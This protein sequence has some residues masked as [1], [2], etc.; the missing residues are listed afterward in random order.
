MVKHL[1]V[2]SLFLAFAC[3]ALA[4]SGTTNACSQINA[5]AGGTITWASTY[6]VPITV[7]P[8]PGTT[9]FLG[10]S[11]VIIPATG[12]VSVNVPE[13]AT[14]GTYDLKVTFDTPTG[15][16]P[17]GQVQHDQSG[18]GRVIIVTT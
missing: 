16:N 7:A 5:V 8:S 10:Q 12:R 3:S 17:C 13:N 6:S 15:G 1:F 11:Q 4:Q 2:A 14:V 18:G 9:W